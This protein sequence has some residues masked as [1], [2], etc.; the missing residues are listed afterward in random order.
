M[1]VE[2]AFQ[3]E[4]LPVIRLFTA[5][6]LLAELFHHLLEPRAR[7]IMHLAAAAEERSS[8]WLMD[9]GNCTLHTLQPEFQR[10]P[11]ETSIALINAPLEHAG[12]WVERW[13]VI[14]GVFTPQTSRENLLKGIA[15]LLAGQ[16]WLPRAVTAR[17]VQRLR[18]LQRP[19]SD[20]LTERERE[21]LTL[22]GRG[23]SNA[24]IGQTLCLSPHTV[25]S[26][27]HNLL[28]KTGAANRTEAAS[29]F[30]GSTVRR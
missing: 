13:P 22:V 3:A 19:A 18:E 5:N 11:A 10:C 2:P 12:A 17:L 20:V 9:A 25:K 8:L 15:A 30:L 1:D 27:I 14:R 28:R 16:D 21:I 24:A 6:A 7:V 4:A 29:R 26:H 23:F